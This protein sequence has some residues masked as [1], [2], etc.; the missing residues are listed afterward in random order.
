MNNHL[1]VQ[2]I[3]E[4]AILILFGMVITAWYNA[5]PRSDIR[6]TADWMNIQLENFVPATQL[7][8]IADALGAAPGG[9]PNRHEQRHSRPVDAGKSV[10]GDCEGHRVPVLE[11]LPCLPT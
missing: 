7:K 6:L 11:T 8:N 1:S 10:P 4:G 2:R 3:V 9:D 5:P